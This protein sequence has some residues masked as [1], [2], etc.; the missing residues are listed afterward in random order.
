[1]KGV[2]TMMILQKECGEVGRE[3][4]AAGPRCRAEHTPRNLS[5]MPASSSA[6]M[7][8]IITTS[9]YCSG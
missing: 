1:M 4:W 5:P 2:M 8:I 6:K 9:C 7:E 3:E